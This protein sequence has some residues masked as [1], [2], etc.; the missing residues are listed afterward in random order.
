M[1]PL[2]PL[3][4]ITPS[5]LQEPPVTTA[6][7]SQ[8]ACG[9]PPAAS[10]FFNFPPAANTTY[11]LSNDQKGKN[12][13]PSVPGKSFGSNESSDRT[14]RKLRPSGPVAGKASFLPSGER[15]KAIP[16][17]FWSGGWIWNR[18]GSTTGG[19]SRKCTKAS[20][21]ASTAATA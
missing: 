9:G 1:T 14:Q 21:A 4:R 7:A 10:I 13:A 2:L 11:L 17:R 8:S 5:G 3:K 12:V 16:K 19:F 20:N 18:T 6:G 15:A